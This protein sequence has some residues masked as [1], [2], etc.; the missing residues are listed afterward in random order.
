MSDEVLLKKVL[1]DKVR[2][3]AYNP[4]EMDSAKFTLLS[5]DVEEDGM[6][7]PVIVIED[8]ETPGH[9]V[10]VDGEHR[11]RAVKASGASEVLVSVKEWDEEYAKLMTV[12]RNILRGEL[13]PV[14]L[15]RLVRQIEQRTTLTPVDIRKRMGFTTEKEFAKVYRDPDAVRDKALAVLEEQVRTAGKD[16]S[17]VSAMVRAIVLKYGDKL[18]AGILCFTLGESLVLGLAVNKKIAM[19]LVAIDSRL[20]EV[21]LNDNQVSELVDG[22]L[23]VL[24]EGLE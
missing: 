22:M 9:Y 12:R 8:A 19:R 4:N 7:Q 16:I 21:K 5:E 11:W 13:N 1:V 2:P 20:R 10:I 18:H 6:D 17:M 15:G 3:N 23:D 24:E 14:K